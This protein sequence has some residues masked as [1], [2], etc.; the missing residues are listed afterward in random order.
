ML[1]EL[2]VKILKSKFITF[3]NR[4]KKCMREN[5]AMRRVIKEYN[6]NAKDHNNNLTKNV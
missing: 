3:T 2:Y 4:H 5:R 1:K 6:K